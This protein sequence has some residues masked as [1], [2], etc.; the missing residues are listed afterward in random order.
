MNILHWSPAFVSILKLTNK[1]HPEGSK[2]FCH[3]LQVGFV[4]SLYYAN[5]ANEILMISN[6]LRAFNYGIKM[7]M[8]VAFALNLF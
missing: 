7:Q 6:F 8:P 1:I 4:Q 5:D 3:E 2:I